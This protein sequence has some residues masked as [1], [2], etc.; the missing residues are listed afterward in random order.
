[1]PR[2]TLDSR[3]RAYWTRSAGRV[4]VE[5]FDFLLSIYEWIV[6]LGMEMEIGL[7]LMNLIQEFEFVSIEYLMKI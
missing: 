5:A 2:L 7:D 1:M 6:F 4:P 3:G